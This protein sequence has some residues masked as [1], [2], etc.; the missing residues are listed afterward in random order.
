MSALRSR[1]IVMWLCIAALVLSVLP[2]YAISL[3]NHPY[4]DDYGFSA[5]V[6]QAWR[7]TGS[8]GA[9]LRQAVQ[10]ARNVR[11]TW[12]GTYTGTLLSNLQP[13]I[14]SEKLYFIGSFALITAFLLCFGAF[15]RTLFHR[16]FGMPKETSVSLSCLLL[17]LS[18]Q[19]LPDVGEAFYWFNGGVGNIFIYSLM[20]LALTLGYFLYCAKGAWRV[21]LLTAALALLMVLLGG[22]SYGG[23][24]MG[25]CL[26]AGLVCWMFARR[27]PRKWLFIALWALFLACFLYSAFAPGNGVRARIVGYSVS[28]VKAI[29]QALY[30]GMA[31]FGGYL[32][33]PV[34]GASLLCAPA[35]AKAAKQSCFSFAHP[36][37]ALLGAYLLYC[38][39]FVPPL[40]SIASIGGGRIVNTYYI[41]FIALWFAWL[42]VFIGWACKRFAPAFEPSAALRRGLALFAACL[43]AVGCLGFKRA[44]DVL[45]GAQNLSGASAALSIVTCEAKTY[46]GEMSAREALLNDETQPVVTLKPLTATPAVLM[47]DLLTPDALYDARPSLC[48]YYDKQAV[49]IEGR[50][51][52]Q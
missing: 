16:V 32:T 23:G 4:Y 21:G 44:D 48:L 47:D 46:D 24:L 52:A 41:S 40:Y 11:A 13:G 45:L 3:Y 15:F 12:Q 2:L 8:L 18:V 6:H 19:L 22:G 34:L 36:W 20:A 49:V 39:Q 51:D 25:L 37:L 7:Q 35:M 1:R 38:T 9:V 31:Q 29:A 33:L 42:Y 17:F 50:E 14:F 43:V 30:Y 5:A 10:S 28:P 26:F 27:S